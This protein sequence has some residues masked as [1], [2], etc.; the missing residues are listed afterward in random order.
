V[1]SRLASTSCWY[2][3]YYIKHLRIGG[4]IFCHG[5]FLLYLFYLSIRR[6]IFI[7]DWS[8]VYD[9]IH[10]S[11]LF[12][13]FFP[14][15]TIISIILFFYL[16]T[17]CIFGKKLLVIIYVRIIYFSCHKNHESLTHIVQ[18]SH[19]RLNIVFIISFLYNLV[20]L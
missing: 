12:L 18:K 10:W 17:L 5:N 7:F 11:P 13:H 20:N 19:P 9:R 14:L 3:Y 6:I 16:A 4:S 8:N 2:L 1:L 15:Y